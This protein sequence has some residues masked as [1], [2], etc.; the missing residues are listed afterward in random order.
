MAN[1]LHTMRFNLCLIAFVMLVQTAGAQTAAKEKSTAYLTPKD[2]V[3]I[4]LDEG[5]KYILHPVKPKQTLFSLCKY[6]AIGLEELYEHNPAFR[7]DPV[8]KTGTKVKIPVPNKAIIRYK[9]NKLIPGHSA[10]LYYKVVA[11]DN[12]YSICK[13]NFAMPVDT[14]VKRN[15]LKSQN[16][17][18]GQI[19]HLG[20]INTDG[21]QSEW[22]GERPP[23]SDD[24]LL[25]RYESEKSHYREV[26][27]Q[28]VCFWQRDS[29]EKGDMYALHREALLGT[30]IE[31]YNPMSRR[32]V[33]AKVIGRIP[34]GYER[35]VEII[36]SPEA[37][38][39]IGARDP[40]FF[41]KLRFL[42]V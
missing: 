5:Q 25:T 14:I 13:K 6:Y 12:L 11:G 2:S 8:L 21:I 10:C 1:K 15:K 28:G 7:T 32:T 22:R 24:V 27:S 26:E 41:V 29:P 20:W 3:F 38:R 35:N 36:L 19:L 31:V 40:K 42:K 4:V 33:H 9:N 17:K 16:V 39:Q 23:P 34:E 30:V 18:E 37:A